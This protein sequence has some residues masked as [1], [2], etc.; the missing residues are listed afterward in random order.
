MTAWVL[1]LPKIALTDN[2]E[3][4]VIVT[5]KHRNYEYISF[6]WLEE[7]VNSYA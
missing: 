4:S 6:L 5:K 7:T 1:I 2:H 3:I